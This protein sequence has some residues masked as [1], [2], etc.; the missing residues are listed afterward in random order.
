MCGRSHSTLMLSID[1]ARYLPTRVRHLSPAEIVRSARDVFASAQG[2]SNP[3]GPAVAIALAALEVVPP[4]EHAGIEVELADVPNDVR[5]WIASLAGRIARAIADTA[6]KL[7][8]ERTIVESFLDTYARRI[9]REPISAAQRAELTGLFQRTR[10]HA[11]FT[12]SL[13]TLIGRLFGDGRF[14]TRTELGVRNGGIDHT[15]LTHHE[16]ASALSHFI[17]GTAPS[18]QLLDAAGLGILDDARV[19]KSFADVMLVDQRGERI[20]GVRDRVPEV[21]LG[22]AFGDQGGTQI[23]LD[24]HTVAT[25]AQNARNPRVVAQAIVASPAFKTRKI[26]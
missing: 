22:L 9:F 23:R 14:V 3:N 16:L 4:F 7:Y 26:A 15:T 17:W 8:A 21:L 20:L 19:L 13:A 11:S 2:I 1:G 12:M 24:E 18:D 25:I 10:E 5:Q 6:P